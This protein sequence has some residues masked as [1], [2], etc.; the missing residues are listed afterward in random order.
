M[1]VIKANGVDNA[2]VS[3]NGRSQEVVL[4]KMTIWRI[5]RILQDFADSRIAIGL[6]RK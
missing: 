3:V 6:K 1:A 2:N 4:S 5:L